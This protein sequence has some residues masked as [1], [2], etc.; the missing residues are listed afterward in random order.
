[1]AKRRKNGDGTVRLRKDGRWEGRIVIGYD[2]AG[3]PKTKNV[4]AKTKLECTERLE[5]L[6]EE[7][8]AVTERIKPDMRFG[9]WIDFWYQT[10]CKPSIRLTTQACYENRVY[11]HIIPNIGKIPLNKLT[12]AD[13]QQF[14]AK[15]KKEGRLIRTEQF[16]DGLSDR[17]VRACHGNCRS[18]LE[19]A[20][21]DGLIR[22]NPAVGCKLPPKKAKEMQVLTRE[23]LQRFLI[24]ANDEGYYELFLLEL[25]TGMR[26][27]EILALQ[28]DDLNFN[29]GELHIKR[30]VYAVKGEL[31]ISTPKTKASIR[32]VVLPPSLINL[33]AEY[34]QT[35]DSKWIFPSPLDNSKTRNPSS[36][37]KRLQIILERAGCKKVRFHDLRHTF[38]TMA[39]E[40][41]MDIK[42]L[43]A[44]IGHVSAATTLDIYSHITDTMQKQAAVNIDRK[45]AKSDASM[46]EQENTQPQTEKPPV[47]DFEPYVGKVRKP[48]TGCVT[49]INDHLF[50]GRFTP[51]GADGKRIA[52]NIYASTREECEEKLAELI[53]QMKAE[54]EDEKAKRKAGREIA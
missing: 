23:E 30:Q 4:L 34:K 13:L 10:Y 40:Y 3:M 53:V 6:K 54:I 22:A 15:V 39:L 48:G 24:Q 42:T 29:N 32:T 1:M 51:T 37:R 50:E 2:E 11:K 5:K 26:R 18:A 19:K 35:V 47:S 44:T 52:K 28:W 45:I 36:V 21:Q 7:C 20:V 31:H 38:S 12:G 27:G 33:L 8:G 16:G 25:G 46:P 41:G 43:S 49:M 14:Y 17:M 9:E